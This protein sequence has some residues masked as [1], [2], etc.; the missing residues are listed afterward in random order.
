MEKVLKDYSHYIVKLP[1]VIDKQTFSDIQ[2]DIKSIVEF[3]KL[4]L[5]TTLEDDLIIINGVGEEQADSFELKRK[6]LVCP[7]YINTYSFP[8]DIIVASTLI[9]LKD[10]LGDNFRFCSDGSYDNFK[11]ALGLFKV[12]LDRRPPVIFKEQL[13][14]LKILSELKDLSA[15]EQETLEN[16][17]KKIFEDYAEKTDICIY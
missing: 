15:F 9:I 10:Y 16:K 2:S 17:L 4:P 3:T 7:N 6:K 8:Y 11:E 12:A 1:K 5:E 13:K 14:Q